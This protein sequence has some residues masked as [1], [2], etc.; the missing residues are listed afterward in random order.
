ME[1]FQKTLKSMPRLLN[2][3]NVH[4]VNRCFILPFENTFYSY[5]HRFSLLSK[6]E[7]PEY[8]MLGNRKSVLILQC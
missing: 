8:N 1:P 2:L 3:K 4:K 5:K 7:I 6:M